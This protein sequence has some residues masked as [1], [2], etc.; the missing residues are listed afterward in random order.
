MYKEQVKVVVKEVTM[1]EKHIRRS[2]KAMSSQLNFSK[3]RGAKGWH[4]KRANG[5]VGKHSATFMVRAL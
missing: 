3:V 1:K 2:L 4:D 5:K